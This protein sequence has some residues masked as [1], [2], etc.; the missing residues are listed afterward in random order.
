M[1][2]SRIEGIQIR[3]V[4]ATVSVGQNSCLVML[5]LPDVERLGRSRGWLVLRIESTE[6]LD[7]LPGLH[8]GRED[9]ALPV[10]GDVVQR[11]EHA[12]LAAGSAEA[13]ERLLGYAVDDP[14]LAVH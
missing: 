3:P 10:H 11:R 2:R 12:D 5:A 7:A 13:A 1:Q 6:L 14:H 4:S 9:V 8:L